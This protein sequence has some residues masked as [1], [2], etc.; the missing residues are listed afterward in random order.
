MDAK[1]SVEE[2]KAKIIETYK[3]VNGDLMDAILNTHYTKEV[4]LINEA[5]SV[6]VKEFKGINGCLT[7]CVAFVNVPHAFGLHDA[8]QIV[9]ECK[10]TNT[11]TGEKISPTR[12]N[13]GEYYREQLKKNEDMLLSF[14][15]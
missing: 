3:K 2:T 15:K 8:N 13:A 5:A 11:I 14:L 10:F 4:L 12:H 6:G 1:M 7:T 9:A